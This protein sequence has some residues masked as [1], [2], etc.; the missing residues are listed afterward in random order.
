MKST[1]KSQRN[2]SFKIQAFQHFQS[3]QKTTV[4]V[5]E[6]PCNILG[7]PYTSKGRSTE[8]H[9]NTLHAASRLSRL[10]FFSSRI[11]WFRLTASDLGFNGLRL[12]LSSITLHRNYPLMAYYGQPACLRAKCICLINEI[13]VSSS[14]MSPDYE[15][16]PQVSARP[17]AGSCSH[18]SPAG[19]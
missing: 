15:P 1:A 8:D 13:P 3:G 5:I 9:K 12:I 6:P 10:L 14:L 2:W 17:W 7:L 18:N 16:C 11:L 19:Q 4:K